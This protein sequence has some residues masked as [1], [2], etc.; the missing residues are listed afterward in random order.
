MI[1]DQFVKY[2]KKAISELND[3]KEFVDQ[4]I[5][6]NP[7][8][9]KLKD[10]RLKITKLLEI[11]EMM[12]DEIPSTLNIWNDHKRLLRETSVILRELS[13]NQNDKH[14]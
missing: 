9:I 4:K 1:L 13:Q 7:N 12:D 3:V 8:N 14:D 5:Q 6:E 10:L 11:I 2:N